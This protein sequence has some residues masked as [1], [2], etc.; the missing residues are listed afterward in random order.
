MV[1]NKVQSAQN[2]RVSP[3]GAI[4]GA[5]GST[6][7]VDEL[8]MSDGEKYRWSLVPDRSDYVLTIV[9][10]DLDF[11]LRAPIDDVNAFGFGSSVRYPGNAAELTI[12]FDDWWE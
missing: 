4:E 12:R 10:K 11:E 7:R 1:G 8:S 3:V 2:R 9:G 5:L 6:Y